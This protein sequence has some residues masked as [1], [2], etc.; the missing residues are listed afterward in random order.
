M[1]AYFVKVW[2]LQNNTSFPQY[3]I[4][5]DAKTST[6]SQFAPQ[7]MVF[8]KFCILEITERAITNVIN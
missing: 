8:L 3:S 7:V 6:P 5:N 4:T 2:G 1:H